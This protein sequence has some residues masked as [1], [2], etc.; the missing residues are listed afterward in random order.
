[1]WRFMLTVGLA[2]TTMLIAL[3]LPVEIARLVL[4]MSLAVIGG[5][6]LGFALAEDKLS[7]LIVESVQFVVFFLVALGGVTVSWWFLAGGYFAH[8][9]WDF[10]HHPRGIRTRVPAW[11]IPACVIYDW[12]V[13]GFIV[14]WFAAHV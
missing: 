14:V 8:G 1:M 5:I 10:A 2:L 4:G 3:L 11:Y 7:S 13:G 9:L 6:Y 12:L